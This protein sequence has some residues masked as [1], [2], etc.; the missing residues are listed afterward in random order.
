MAKDLQNYL[1]AFEKAYP[2]HLLRI[3]KELDPLNHEV[4]AIMKHLVNEGRYPIVLFEK[5]RDVNRNSSRFPYVDNLFSTRELCAL[6]LGLAPE[7]SGMEMSLEFSRREA[8]AIE[9]V[10]IDRKAA[11]VKEVVRSGNDVDVGELPAARYHEMDVGPYLTMM[12]V[13][14]GEGG[15]YEVSFVKHLILDA[16]TM[17]VSL[18]HS[19]RKHLLN[20]VQENE[21]KGIK[22]PMAL[23]LGH[24]PA[25]SLGAGALT[26]YGNNDYGTIG[27]IMEEP[28]RLVA[29]ETWG[30]SFLVPADSEIVVEGE[31]IPG[32]REVQNP[33]GE[34]SGYYQP[35]CLMPVMTV[36]A[37][38]HRKNAIMQGVFPGHSSHFNMGSIPK[39]GSLYKEIK[40][41]APEVTAVFMPHSGVGRA[42][43]Y[44]SIKKKREGDA[45]HAGLMPFL[46]AGQIQYVVV[47]DDDVN[48]FD[49][50]E[51]L[52]AIITRLNITKG[53]DLIKNMPRYDRVLID[54]TR[55]LDRPFPEKNRI[56]EEVMKRIK[57]SD[58]TG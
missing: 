16:R 49:E 33:F 10:V 54:A 18:H 53:V 1:D 8:A 30:E 35:Q 52:W 48:V 39:E 4:A 51:V 31:V 24:H 42:S 19:L 43:C 9:P 22:T 47:V 55:P 45:K 23:V 2:Q 28:V 36:T 11:P 41:I 5:V 15:F 14:K 25:F 50:Q 20:I 7:K 56:P 38:T 29:S 12:D 6:A 27:S 40:K 57:L 17:T 3:R 58:Y 32:R 26:P 44:V 21:A 34:Y 13:M 46:Q 37:M